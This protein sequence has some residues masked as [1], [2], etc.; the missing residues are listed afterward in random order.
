MHVNFHLGVRRVVDVCAA[1]PPMLVPALMFGQVGGLVFRVPKM[2][3]LRRDLRHRLVGRKRRKTRRGWLQTH[4]A[5]PGVLLIDD[6]EDRR[7]LEVRA[8]AKIPGLPFP[9]ENV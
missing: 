2:G 6:V 8:Q 4:P 1:L 7:G 5:G 9:K 3:A